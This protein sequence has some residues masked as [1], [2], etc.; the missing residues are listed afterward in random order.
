MK[1]IAIILGT[2]PE[3]IKL[4]PVYTAFKESPEFETFLVSTGQHREML[5]QIFD[6]FQIT[7]DVELNVMKPNQTLASLS[8]TLMTE[9]DKLYAEQKFDA[10]V[11]QGDTTTCMIGSL[12]A[13]Y[14]QIKVLHVE[15]GLRTYHKFS[16]FPEEINRKITGVVA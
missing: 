5:Q 8:A 9:L 4:L 15:A 11:V 16:P 12:V 1:K 2:R 13:F 10:V 6:F 7:P 3:A 14:H